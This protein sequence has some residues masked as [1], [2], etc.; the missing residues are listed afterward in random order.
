MKAADNTLD[1]L[2][3][4]AGILPGYHDQARA[5]VETSLRAR[6]AVLEGLGFDLSSAS[7]VRDALAVL[8]VRRDR[9]VP[10]CIVVRADAPARIDM[11]ATSA[12]HDGLE[13][14]LRCEDGTV[15]SGAGRTI[16]L[17]ALP[18]G[19]HR[20]A[21]GRSPNETHALVLAAPAQCWHPPALEGDARGWGIAAQVYGLR[22]ES[23]LGIGTY[24]DAGRL[25]AAAGLR[26]ASF[27]GLSPVHALFAGDAQRYSPYS[28]SSRLFLQT[29]L[30]DPLSLGG[31]ADAAVS[32]CLADTD[33]AALVE[34][35]RA[36]PLIDYVGVV[37]LTSR[38]FARAYAAAGRNDAAFERFCAERGDA[39]WRHATFEALSEHFRS[40][41]MA[42]LGA[43]PEPYRD[44]DS[45]MVADFAKE[46]RDSVRFH[47][48]LQYQADRQF[49]A[50]AR[51]AADSG[52]ELGLYRDLAVGADRG[53]SEFW[54]AP[55]LYGA[56]L[57][58]GAP[59]DPLGPKGQD[60][61]FPPMNPLVLEDEG[62]Q[63]FRDLVAANMR[64]AGAIRIDHAFQLERLYVSPLGLGARHG[65]YIT[66]PLEALLAVLRIESHRARCMVIA[67]DLGTAP[68]GFSK[69]IMASGILSSKLVS[70]ERDETGCF[71][72][73]ASFPRCAL[74]SLGTHDLPTFVG[75]WRGLDIDLRECFGVFDS[76][77]AQRERQARTNDRLAF[78]RSLAREDLPRES[79]PEKAPLVS[80]L[81]YLA[82]TPSCLTAVQMEDLVG[83]MQQPNL[84]GLSEGPPN[85]RRRLHETLEDVTAEGGP[86]A[87]GA[88]VMAGEG[89][90]LHA[91]STLALAPPRATYRLQFN[92]DF[93]FDDASK[94]VPYLAELGISH[95]YAS[96]IET[97]RHGSTHGYDVV[98]HTRINPALGGMEGL[99]RLSR[100]LQAH[101][102]GLLLDIV[103][104]HMGIEGGENDW[105]NSVLEF[106]RASPHAR[107]FDINWCR[108]GAKE[109]VLL[110]VLGAPY[111]EALT[112][113]DISLRFDADRGG[114]DL[115]YFD[116]AF[117]LRPRSD[118]DL[119]RLGAGASSSISDCAR[120]LGAADERP[121]EAADIRAEF[122]VLLK[123]DP[124]AEGQLAQFA[125][126]VS[127]TCDEG[128]VSLLHRIVEE[129]HYRLGFWRLASSEL[130]YRRFF[131]IAGLA[132]VRVEDRAV[133]EKS[134][135]LA[136]DLIERGLVQ[137]LRIDHVD[138]LA[139]P[140]AYLQALQSVLG[141]GFYIVVEKILSP[142]EEL[143]AWPIAG[144]TGYEA[145][146]DL[147]QIFVARD[148]EPTFSL[149]YRAETGEHVDYPRA[150]FAT[151][152]EVAARSFGSEIAD[153][154]HLLVILRDS[155]FGTRDISLSALETA[156]LDLLA[157]FPVYRTYI[158]GD[159]ASAE[160]Q[161]I[162]AE[163]R[164]RAQR[165]TS[166]EDKTALNWIAEILTGT[167]V[168]NSAR[169][170]GCAFCRR[171]QQ[172]S[173]PVMAKGVEDTLFYRYGRWIVLNEVGGDPS[174]FGMTP[175]EFH[176]ANLHRSHHWPHMLLATA[177]HDTKRGEDA[178]ARLLAMTHLPDLWQEIVERF[179][180]RW[181]ELGSASGPDAQERY[182]LWQ[183]LVAAW[184]AHLAENSTTRHR[185]LQRAI[186]FAQKAFREAKR[187]TS[188]TAP[189]ETHESTITSFLTAL[190]EDAG[191]VSDVSTRLRPVFTAGVSVTLARLVLKLTMPGV[192]DIYQGTEALDLS[193]V[194]PDNR[195]PVDY[196]GL[197]A[198]L[199]TRPRPVDSSAK[200]HVMQKLLEDRAH[201]PDL[202]SFGS[203]EPIE[204]ASREIVAFERVHRG[205]RLMVVA[206]VGFGPINGLDLFLE[207]GSWRNLVTGETL[208]SSGSLAV[209]DALGEWPALALRMDA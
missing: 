171:F 129:Q 191:F 104:N 194:D 119:L 182:I 155:S 67:E 42:W 43:W 18:M 105:W 143:R 58:V 15:R 84:P 175:A 166:S 136:F 89:R 156:V 164:A 148:N 142:G 56:G 131:E 48:W 65:A 60:W 111:P 130:N 138:G 26:G 25:A 61:G 35:L 11:Q 140:T 82:R 100:T 124:A 126:I 39:L 141:P 109:R 78:D 23:S 180:Q 38:V 90:G 51:R 196:A 55:H 123:A 179:D 133:F 200:I 152:R 7:A 83:D 73:P 30:I 5:Y 93:T 197:S 149:F 158:E 19:Y 170:I 40:R 50:A 207:R 112:R 101:G 85:W 204:T 163:A 54:S 41:G 36:T 188:W 162:I 185:F 110:P 139:A 76:T 46:N 167:R 31:A 14:S 134:H 178:R 121:E 21:L 186:A 9:P 97:A 3:T 22:S 153:L 206:R 184:P 74:A 79:D 13:W 1:E 190:L 34:R 195:R 53:G 33:V 177:T 68:K 27:L 107:T 169:D 173:G 45:A 72:A 193:F 122:R 201:C 66:Y 80:A 203:Y 77:Q 63:G 144:T 132:G 165:Y 62:L 96:P 29:W 187:N 102:M 71:A 150:M 160:D 64:H 113:G 92:A 176:A 12:R 106:G 181:A 157:G 95:L 183:S 81:R 114:F 20:L 28:P 87:R 86:L 202:Y 168:P 75:W 91:R 59:P 70:F 52:M 154:V 69:R 57:S 151:K 98:D 159:L 198:L 118:A 8:R 10:P 47:A 108:A 146:A 147:D 6:T 137:G 117:P 135:R 205:H 49:E 4:A 208:Q 116:K 17:D 2:A 199:K 115:I 125:K 44:A 127:A 145:L 88:A 37:E 209:A 174:R 16:E 94:I 128:D 192:P 172:L 161:Q 120:R 189:N 103:P 24:T 99:E 32:E